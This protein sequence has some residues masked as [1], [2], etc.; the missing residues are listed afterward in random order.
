MSIQEHSSVKTDLLGYLIL[1]RASTK[2]QFRVSWRWPWCK[3]VASVQYAELILAKVT[4]TLQ[5]SSCATR[6]T[7]E[8]CPSLAITCRRDVMVII[9][10]LSEITRWRRLVRFRGQLADSLG[11]SVVCGSHM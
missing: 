4:R 10:L 3:R 7:R 8:A 5:F 1:S 9:V 6:L 2:S 11:R